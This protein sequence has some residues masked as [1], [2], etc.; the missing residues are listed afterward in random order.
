MD[1]AVLVPVQRG[2][3]VAPLLPP[4]WSSTVSDRPS[5]LLLSLSTRGARIHLRRAR[6][7]LPGYGRWGCLASW[8]G[9]FGCARAAPGLC[10]GEMSTVARLPFSALAYINEDLIAASDEE[11]ANEEVEEALNEA[12]ALLSEAEEWQRAAAE[13]PPASPISLPEELLLRILSLLPAC[14]IGRLGCACRASAPYVE[15]GLIARAD[16][17]GLPTPSGGSS[18]ARTW[19]LAARLLEHDW[20]GVDLYPKY[21]LMGLHAPLR[22]AIAACGMVDPCALQQRS[23]VPMSN[24]RDVLALLRPTTTTGNDFCLEVAAMAIGLLAAVDSTDLHCQAIVLCS[25]PMQ[26]RIVTD[27]VSE[28]SRGLGIVIGKLGP[29]GGLMGAGSTT[30]LV[31]STADETHDVEQPACHVIIDSLLPLSPQ[32]LARRRA[33]LT[34]VSRLVFFEAE[35]VTSRAV[36]SAT[37]IGKVLSALLDA[38]PH[39]SLRV[40][41][42]SRA[43]SPEVLRLLE[44]MTN[45]RETLAFVRSAHASYC[46]RRRTT[47]RSEGECQVAPSGLGLAVIAGSPGSFRRTDA[48]ALRT[49]PRWGDRPRPLREAVQGGA[50]A[51]WYADLQALQPEQDSWGWLPERGLL[52]RR[53]AWREHGWRHGREGAVFGLDVPL[54]EL[55]QVPPM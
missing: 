34:H 4:A 43:L 15:I 54:Q 13:R 24:G 39:H 22:A 48:I 16:A 33:S 40:G 19:S 1:P 42:F 20:C 7:L 28:L 18:S 31:I 55:M 36:F 27:V 3:S 29:V 38:L 26:A 41:L 5:L 47:E 6:L 8:H 35:R 23:I 37:P 49:A 21:E 32:L 10:G 9:F 2:Q 14:S 25:S 11:S 30:Q 12:E 52:A 44:R 46:E 45:G 17:V 53:E 51:F 50:A